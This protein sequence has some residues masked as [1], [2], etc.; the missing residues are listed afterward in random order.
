MRKNTTWF[1]EPLD[2]ATNKRI[3][4]YL[5][6]KCAD[7]EARSVPCDDGKMHS[8]WMMSAYKDVG[9]FERSRIVDQ[10]LK[11]EIW[12]R[13]GSG[14]IRKWGFEHRISRAHTVVK[15]FIRRGR[16][17]KAKKALQSA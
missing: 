12:A 7:S 4:E 10:T 6:E 1:L 17:L 14:I 2:A 3:A 9:H 5:V 8:L 16:H 13:E 15:R 11:F